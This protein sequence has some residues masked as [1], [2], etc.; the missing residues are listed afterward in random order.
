M[1]WVFIIFVIALVVFKVLMW[2][3][4]RESEKMAIQMTR[5]EILLEERERAIGNNKI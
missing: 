3:D 4:N 5:S 1:I 2:S